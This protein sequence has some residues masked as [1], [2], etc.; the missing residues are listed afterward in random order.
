[1]NGVVS[2]HRV[3]TLCA[4]WGD[5][6]GPAYQRLARRLR[7]CIADG[8][9]ATGTRLPSERE[10]TARLRV[11]R[12]TVAHVYAV[13]REQGYLESRRGSGSVTRLP[14]RAGRVGDHL[15][16]PR[17]Q[18]ADLPE[19]IDLTCT[20]P[21]APPG[22]VAA[23]EEAVQ[24][25]PVYLA[26]TG[27]Y[28][29]GLPVL[30]EALA[31]RYAGRGLPTDPDQ[32]VVVPGALAGVAVAVQAFVSAG[33][34]VLVE[35]PT[36]PNAIT[37]FRAR[38]ARLVGVPVDPTGWDLDAAAAAVRQVGPRA[39]YLIPD[40]HNPTGALLSETARARMAEV[41][42]RGRVLPIVDES[43]VEVGL[44][45]EQMPS[46]FAAILDET[47]TVGSASKA[48][49]GGLRIG[50]IRVPRSRVDAVVRARL[51]LDLGCAPLEQLVLAELLRDADAVLAHRRE[52]LRE[53][54][55]A[56]R[57]ALAAHLPDWTPPATH[58]GQALW[59]RLPEP[60]STAVTV[61]AERQHVYLAAGP[62]FSPDEGLEG[63]LR[64]PYSLP[65]E[66][67]TEAVRRLALA[68][69]DARRVGASPPGRAPLVA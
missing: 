62:A 68:W 36:Y 58:G 56:L 67:L 46:P 26:D 49:W 66:P 20:A 2:A 40:F 41:L 10:L 37:A 5:E 35:S 7:L 11:S 13:L 3:A 32:I 39:A 27:Y 34:R 54:R 65:A 57:Q 63:F 30:R 44:D 18:G 33:D 42:A 31:A 60:L 17:A 64:L 15:L 59:V 9:I 1:M 16:S 51:G 52:S 47:L 22:L 24:A 28:P 14:V 21:S 55:R 45:D 12:T 48:F 19:A 50:W 61:A 6:P 29:S 23:Y 25:L 4:G 53:S 43:M 38:H 69:Q 8:R